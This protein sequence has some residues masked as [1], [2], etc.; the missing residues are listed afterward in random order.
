MKYKLRMLRHINFKKLNEIIT[1]ISKENKKSK[2]YIFFDMILSYFIHGAGYYDYYLFDFCNLTNK[3][4][5]TF[6]T[7]SR[8]KKLI[9][10][11]NDDKYTYIFD[12]KTEFSKVFKD[13]LKRDVLILKETNLEDFKKFMENKDVIIAKPDSMESG[14]GIRKFNKKDYKDIESLYNDILSDKRLDLVEEVIK[15]HDYYAKFYPDS[16]NCL[17][18]VTILVDGTVYPVYSMFKMGNNGDFRDN[19]DNGGICCFVDIK[20]G[21]IT[22]NGRAHGNHVILNHPKTNVYFKGCHLPYFE[23]AKELV[24]KAAKEVPEVGFVGWD[25]FVT[26]DGPGIIEGNNYPGYDFP[27]FPEYTKNKTGTWAFYK[28]LIKKLK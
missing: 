22:E 27:Q 4:R 26:N 25:V 12:K 7:R 20:T 5:S 11:M 18:I 23:E 14:K 15:Q 6:V 19:Y 17:R 16:V 10:M 2:I 24:C 13:Y 3:Q 28:K 21:I 1:K 9:S 8:N